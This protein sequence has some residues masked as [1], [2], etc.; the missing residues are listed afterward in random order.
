MAAA[1]ALHRRHPRRRA[2]ADRVVADLLAARR[3]RLWVRTPAIVKKPRAWIPIA[4]VA[5]AHRH[6]DDARQRRAQPP[7]L[8]AGERAGAA[9]WIDARLVEHLVGDPVADAG[10]ERLVEQERLHRRRA[11]GASAWRG[12]ARR[13]SDRRRTRRRRCAGRARPARRRGAPPRL[14]AAQASGAVA[15]PGTIVAFGIR[16]NT[17]GEVR[18][19]VERLPPPRM[20]QSRPMSRSS[21]YS[22]MSGGSAN[23]V[24]PPII[25]PVNACVSSA[26]ANE[27]LAAPMRRRTVWLT[28]SRVVA[29]TTHAQYSFGSFLLAT[30]MVLAEFASGIS[31]FSQNCA[32]SA[33]AGSI[34]ITS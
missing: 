4:V 10:G 2:A 26:V 16:R 21:T 34:G 6:R 31:Y 19:F 15:R 33:K 23:T 3:V 1:S 12:C 28:S 13:R 11:R 18:I 5:R 29:S 25:M 22:G 24:T 20:S 14:P 32:V 7:D 27:T 30:T 8:V 9:P 17:S